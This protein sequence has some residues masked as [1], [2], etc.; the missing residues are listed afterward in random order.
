MS[1]KKIIKR[2]KQ[3]LVYIKWHDAHSEG[4]WKTE[5]ETEEYINF[6]YCLVENVGWLI[7]ENSKEIVLCSRRLDWIE[8]NKDS[9]EYG[10]FQKIPKPWIVNRKYLK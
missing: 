1:L 9:Y 5:N 8:Q 3:K 4:G 6:D 7:F 10:I 2:E